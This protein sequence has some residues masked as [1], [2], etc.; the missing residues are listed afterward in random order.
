MRWHWCVFTVVAAAFVGTAR[1]SAGHKP[2]PSDGEMNDWGIVVQQC[3]LAVGTKKIAN[4][5]VGTPLLILKS[6]GP[7]LWVN[8]GARGWIRANNVVKLLQA[9]RYFTDWIGR[10]PESANAYLGRGAAL[11]WQAKVKDANVLVFGK[12]VTPLEERAMQDLSQAIRLAPGS[13]VAY[14]LRAE[15]RILN[16]DC[17]DAF[18]DLD[19]AIQLD[20][21]SSQYHFRRGQLWHRGRHNLNQ[22]IADFDRAIAI[23]PQNSDA[24]LCR[25]VCRSERRD[26]DGVLDD[27]NKAIAHEPGFAPA[28]E[29]R[30][31]YY[32]G[33]KQFDMAVADFTQV[34]RRQKPDPI[35]GL[36]DSYLTRAECYSEIGEYE[37]AFAD[38][39][40]SIRKQPDVSNAYAFRAEL[41]AACPDAR[42]RDAKKAM[43]DATKAHDLDRGLPHSFQALAAACA[44]TA[45]FRSAVEWQKKAISDIEKR[46]K[47]A[48]DSNE[49]DSWTD[50]LGRAQARLSLYNASQPL[51][52]SKMEKSPSR[53]D[54]ASVSTQN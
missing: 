13:A 44:E 1:C 29:Y 17:E 27:L 4:V 35:S 18:L 34:I 41:Y 31:M 26:R 33:T 24:L 20:P 22:A 42:F 11:S 47:K 15:I 49:A 30:G 23:D 51:R 43:A 19:Q 38:L 37:H 39:A 54:T 25:A 21:S 8:S 7:W 52:K 28:L 5:D 16:D 6:D 32:Q 3:S 12:Q 14:A 10:E 53:P 50:E 45:D 9:D 40:E 46:S 48:S 36:S 2:D